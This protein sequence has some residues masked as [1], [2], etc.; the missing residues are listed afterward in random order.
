MKRLLIT[1]AALLLAGCVASE[2]DPAKP[3]VD[4]KA[5][6]SAALKKQDI[7]RP[8]KLE[9]QENGW[10]VAT[11]QDERFG[12]LSEREKAAFAERLVLA[13][14]NSLYDKDVTTKYRVTFIGNPPGP[15]LV[16]KFGSGRFI[17]GG[18]FSWGQ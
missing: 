5:V 13:I 15:G 2:P 11:Y 7:A 4:Y 14:R 8:D 17:E 12:R 1:L 3:A 10:L 6:V 16:R 9:L 18:G